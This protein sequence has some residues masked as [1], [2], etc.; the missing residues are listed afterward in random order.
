MDL[1]VGD[2]A[3]VADALASANHGDSVHFPAGIY[4]G[5]WSITKSI[6]LYGDG[7][8]VQGTDTGTVLKPSSA[9][10]PVLTLTPPIEHVMVRD[11]QIRGGGGTG[12]GVGI[13][14]Q[15][16]GSSQVV[17]DLRLSRLAVL[18]FPSHGIHLKGFNET[19]APISRFSAIDCL[20]QGNGG[21]GMF[22]E[23]VFDAFLLA[24]LAK[25]NQQNGI[26]IVGGGASVKSSGFEGNC[27]QAS[28]DPTFANLRV[29]GAKACS[30]DG[31]RLVS[32]DSGSI[33]KGM[34]LV[35]CSGA[36]V[37]TSY[38]AASAAA[39]VQG[40]FVTAS[41]GSNCGP[42][43]ILGNRFKNVEKLI[44]VDPGA[45]VRDLVV[46]P[47]YDETA[48]GSMTLPNNPNRG[49]FASPQVNQGGTS[50]KTGLI[51]PQVSSDPPTANAQPGMLVYNTSSDKL[52]VFDGTTWKSVEF[53]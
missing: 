51:I 32:L 29:E 15:M 13:R 38:F 18:S 7:P 6:T 2:F 46:M 8:G 10:S 49:L 25:S 1:S 27:L 39:S 24:C 5:N 37:G 11:M 22:L 12:S 34:A 43:A 53:E 41:A 44:E 30:V 4:T 28:S 3:T 23:K 36:V 17:S 50:A 26:S 42:I 16:T 9:A 20:V 45:D 33:K 35:N 19:T 52:R 31:C 47:Q 48:S 14:C 40:I 21:K